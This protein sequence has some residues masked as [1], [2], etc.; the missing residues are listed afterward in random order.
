MAT[1]R[2]CRRC[3]DRLDQSAESTSDLDTLRRETIAELR[4][5]IGFGRWCSLLIDPDT[6]IANRGIGETD[7]SHELPRLNLRD[8]RF[9][10]IINSVVLACSREHAGVLS[11]ATGGVLARSWRWREVFASYGVGDELR[12]VAVDDRGCWGDIIL[13]RDSDDPPSTPTTRG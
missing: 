11:A 5:A 2:A 12:A 6:L 7:F 9:G 1:E 4:T 10:D 8:G 13:L 3:R